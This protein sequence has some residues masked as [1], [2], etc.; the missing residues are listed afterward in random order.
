MSTSK[1]LFAGE[2]SVIELLHKLLIFV[3]LI[4]IIIILQI[5]RKLSFCNV[6][7]KKKGMF[8]HS[9]FLA[10]GATLAAGRLVVEDGTVKVY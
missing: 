2:V 6:F 7:Q 10:G 1:R 4:M 8:H 5:L 3:F 9:S